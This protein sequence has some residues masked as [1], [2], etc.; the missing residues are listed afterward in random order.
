MPRRLYL[1][2]PHG[3]IELEL[4]ADGVVFAGEAASEVRPT[5][6]DHC[7]VLDASGVSFDAATS[8]SGTRVW[9]S[10]DGDVFE[11]T[12]GDSAP[13]GAEAVDSAALAPPMAGRVTRVAVAEGQ[14]VRQG[15]ILVAIEAMK[16]E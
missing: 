6:R 1:T 5:S 8:R 11:F 10:I 16:M 9:V 12:V 15:D 4:T 14:R 7:T 3:S 2:G 13:A